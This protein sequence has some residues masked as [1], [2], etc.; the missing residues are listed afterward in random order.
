VREL[1]ALALL[2]IAYGVVLQ[3]SRFCFARAAFELFLLRTREALDGVMAGLL[4]TAVGF[5]AVA[6]VQVEGGAAGRGHLLTLATGPNTIIGGVLFGLGM[7]LAGMCAAGTLQRLGEGYVVAW[8]V[9]A[10]MVVGA[11]LS[12]FPARGLGDPLWLGQWVGL[13]V[14]FLITIAAVLSLWAMLARGRSGSLSERADEGR[15]PS[16]RGLVTAPM[17]GGIALGILNTA[18]MA[19]LAPW[20]IGYPL[21]LVPSVWSHAR[22]APGLRAVLP[23]AALDL[24]LVLG[25]LAAARI[26]GSFRL[27]WPSR[28]TA[29]TAAMGGVLMGCGIQAADACNIGGIFSAIPSLALAG[30]IFLPAVALGTWIGTRVIARLA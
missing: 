10:G 9:L 7:A 24:C 16:L 15:P 2:G 29:F 27:R 25:S 14:A 3:R 23:A 19:L 5:G 6:L 22:A 30:W 17:A 18:Q 20:T 13:P 8:V 1:I 28:Q 11:A 21:A 26:A 4:A 12:P